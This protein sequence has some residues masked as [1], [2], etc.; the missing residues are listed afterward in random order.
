[1][2]MIEFSFY[3]EPND[4]KA[5]E[6]EREFIEKNGYVSLFENLLVGLINKK[7][8]DGVPSEHIKTVHRIFKKLDETETSSL[9]LESSELDFLEEIFITSKLSIPPKIIRL[10]MIYKN[11]V[12]RCV[13]ENT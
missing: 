8:P 3:A 13:S 11:E 9:E 5:D 12:Q 10:F 7:H 1:M 4:W 2:K 6:Q